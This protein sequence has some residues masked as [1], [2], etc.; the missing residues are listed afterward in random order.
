M[1]GVSLILAVFRGP[2]VPAGQRISRPVS[3][4]AIPATILDLVPRGQAGAF[5]SSSLAPLWRA[6]DLQADWPFPVSEVSQQAWGDSTSRVHHGSIR[7]LMSPE[8]HYI[9]YDSLP[10]ELFAWQDAREQHDRASD[11]TLHDVMAE[12]RLLMAARP[13]KRNQEIQN[14]D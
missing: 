14:R 11:S 1:L 3:S 7:S 5:G 2:G 8:W 13:R 9:A 6:G 4:S 12:F 10:E